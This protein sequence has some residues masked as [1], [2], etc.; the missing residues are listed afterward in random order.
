MSIGQQLLGEFEMEL[1]TTRRVLERVPEEK[2][3]FQPHPT[4]MSLG[5]L[6]L[7]VA[8]VPSNVCEMMKV[9][10]FEVTNFVA[11]TASKQKEVLDALD[12]TAATV[13]E[14]LSKASDEWL[15]APWAMTREGRELMRMPRVGLMRVV[16]MNH[17]YHHRGQIAMCLRMMGV[18]VP[19]V[20]GPSGD[21]N[22]F[23]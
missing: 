8:S 5:M 11:P 13:R 14:T 1:Q 2:Y 18:P 7:H 6:T 20:Y 16:G 10:A 15:M 19:S 23:M 22:P 21:E 3:T 4:S 12:H 9:D 17:I